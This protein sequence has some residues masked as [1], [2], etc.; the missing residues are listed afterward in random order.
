MGSNRFIFLASQPRAGST[1][2][3]LVLSNNSQVKTSSEMWV[4]FLLAGLESEF[5]SAR[6]NFNLD[7]AELALFDY[8]KAL[9][10]KTKYTVFSELSKTIYGLKEGE[11]MFFLDKTPRY[12]L[13]LEELVEAYPEAKILLLKRDPEDIFK[14]IITTWHKNNSLRVVAKNQYADL[15][16][17]PYRILEFEKKHAQNPHVM[18][19]KYEDLIHNPEKGFRSLYDFLGLDFTLEDLDFSHNKK[20]TGTLGD[21]T[22][23]KLSKKPSPSLQK[24]ALSSTQKKYVEWYVNYLGADFL[25]SYGYEKA[26]TSKK[27]PKK[28]FKF[29]DYGQAEMVC[30]KNIFDKFF[31]LLRYYI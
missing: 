4:Q 9:P 27:I 31:R 28:F 25:K 23:V 18:S 8:Y 11:E 29:R 20:L 1:M 30:E 15:F 24:Q 13:I 19:V 17:A 6:K 2:T 7:M 3:Q 21:P 26:T 14:S 12:Y 22:G 5:K 10:K 16:I